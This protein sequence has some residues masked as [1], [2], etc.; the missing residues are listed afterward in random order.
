MP[1][2]FNDMEAEDSPDIASFITIDVAQVT[3]PPLV[4]SPPAP[5]EMF[6]FIPSLFPDISF[7]ESRLV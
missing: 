3:P 6:L 1:P 4:K 5:K 2:K 7:L